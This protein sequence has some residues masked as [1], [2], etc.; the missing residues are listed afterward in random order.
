MTWRHVRF[1]G[2]IP[3]EPSKEWHGTIVAQRTDDQVF[4]V[5]VI[6]PIGTGMEKVGASLERGFLQLA[7]YR[8]CA[9]KT[10]ALCALHVNGPALLEGE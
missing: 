3:H 1:G 7:Q 8:D 2:F 9:C 10:N 4:F 5:R 6:V